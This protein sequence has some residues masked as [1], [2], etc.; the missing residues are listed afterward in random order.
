MNKLVSVIMPIY[1]SKAF[2]EESIKSVLNQTYK[3]FELILV[4]DHSDD[5][6]FELASNFLNDKR[7]FITRMKENKGQGLCRN[8]G[9][10]H[11][12]GSMIAFIDSDDVWL[13]NKLE[14]QIKYLEIQN[15]EF[16]CTNFSFIDEFSV[17]FKKSQKMIKDVI[18]Y[19]DLLK[20]NYIGTSTVLI[21]SNLIGNLR[22]NDF[23]KKQDYIFWLDLIKERDVQCYYLNES[24]TEYRKHPYQTTKNK[25]S[26]VLMHF[27]VLK[28]TQ[29]LS[30]INSLYYTI[31]W[32]LN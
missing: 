11:A 5:G 3:E 14:K 9:I 21:N 8:F 18:S 28:S 12:R 7:V 23:R 22:F 29:N 20:N 6:S 30:W 19:S 31:S 4:D 25:L 2:I 15:V 10:N 24:L 27:R 26:S 17:K 16:C 1:N 13:P 32:G